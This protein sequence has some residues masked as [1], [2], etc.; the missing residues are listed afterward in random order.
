MNTLEINNLFP[1]K[2]NIRTEI[3]SEVFKKIKKYKSEKLN[4]QHINK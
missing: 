1:K 3:R 4:R 2:F